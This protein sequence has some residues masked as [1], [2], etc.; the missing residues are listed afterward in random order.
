V[1]GARPRWSRRTSPI[2]VALAALA[3]APLWGAV[4]APSIAARSS[5]FAGTVG[6]K[7]AQKLSFRVAGGHVRDWKATIDA[8][9]YEGD[10]SVTVLIPRAKLD[11]NGRFRSTYRPLPENEAEIVLAGR[12]I[13]G[14][15]SGSV[16]ETGA[17]IFEKQSWSARRR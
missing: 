1:S 9:C 15:A 14:R 16:S 8:A 13:R 6:G 3:C 11:K 12:V 2:V 7:K 17:C 4:A 10:H 5:T